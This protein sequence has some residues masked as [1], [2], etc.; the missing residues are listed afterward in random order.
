MGLAR[1]RRAKDPPPRRRSA[2]V[3]FRQTAIAIAFGA[4]ASLAACNPERKQECEKF[5]VV[6][7]SLD[8]GMPSPETVDQV[9]KDVDSLHLQ[10]QPLEIYATNYKTM[11]AVLSNTLRL[12][13]DPSAPDGTNDVIKTHLREARTARDDVQRYCAQ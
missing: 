4:L 10:D 13:D 6:M 1:Q 5:L 12:K 11:L 2:V 7:K 8:E 9:G 3:T